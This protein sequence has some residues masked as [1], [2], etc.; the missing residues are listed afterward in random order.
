MSLIW[1]NRTLA[2]DFLKL[3]LPPGPGYYCSSQ[4]TN[5]I[6]T[7]TDAEGSSQQKEIVI[8]KDR[9]IT[10]LEGLAEVSLENSAEGF[11]T[12][13]A[14]SIFEQPSIILNGKPKFRAAVNA[15]RQ[16]SLWLDID[17]KGRPGEYNNV[18]DARDGLEEFIQTSGIPAPLIVCSGRGL[19]VYWPF[20]EPLSME[21]WKPL[22]LS[23]KSVCQ[24]LE[25]KVD[26][27][28]THDAASVL[29]IPG[30]KNYGNDGVVRD[31]AV[32]SWGTVT[33]PETLRNKFQTLLGGASAPIPVSSPARANPPQ[34]PTSNMDAL[35]NS[36]KT[37]EDPRAA[38]NGC[39]H[40]RQAG[41]AN[42]FNWYNALKVLTRC[43]KGREV[44]HLVSRE[45][46]Q[47][48]YDAAVVDEKFD[49]AEESVAGPPRCETFE[50]AEN[51]TDEG[52]C[53][54]CEYYKKYS[55]PLQCP[56]QRRTVEVKIE[57]PETEAGGDAAN[58]Y[59]KL[60]PFESDRFRVVK[61]TGIVWHKKSQEDGEWGSQD[62]LLAE[63]EL[64]LDHIN[65]E[66][67]EKGEP[68]RS[69]IFNC[70]HQ[71]LRQETI[72][73]ILSRDLRNFKEWLM[74]RHLS[75]P[76]NVP[77]K[78]ME[79]F[80]LAYINKMRHKVPDNLLYNSLGWRTV[81]DERTGKE[82][83]GFI[84]GEKRILPDR[85]DIIALSDICNKAVEKEFI[86]AGSLEE[87]KKV[88][89]MY[90][91]LNQKQGQ[92]FICAG[93]AAPFMSLH[94][95]ETNA[96]F[97][98]YEPYGG[99]GKSWVLKMVNSIWGHP[100]DMFGR[101]KDT[102]N[103]RYKKLAVRRHL[104]MCIDEVTT[105]KDEE[106]VDMLYTVSGGQEKDRLTGT[107]AGFVSGG[108]WDTITFFTANRSLYEKME[109]YSDQNTATKRRVIEFQCD[110]KDYTNTEHGPYID[111]MI[112]LV[113]N[114]YG[115]AGAYMIENYLRDA[116]A[117]RRIPAELE[118]MASEFSEAGSDS[119]WAAGMSAAIVAGRYAKSLGLI[120]YDMDD[121][122]DWAKTEMVGLR[123]EM[124]S[125]G[126]DAAAVLSSFLN[127]HYDSTLIVLSERRPP[128]MKDPGNLEALD[129][130]IVKKPMH[131]VLVRYARE[132]H[133]ARISYPA[134]KTWCMLRRLSAK[135]ILAEAWEQKLI[136]STEPVP[137]SLGNSVNAL[138]RTR[139]LAITLRA[140]QLD[141]DYEAA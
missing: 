30:T 124:T 86:S 88:V 75:P 127:E 68:H 63:R 111:R 134:F 41:H 114:N 38:V 116:E 82:Q 54:A 129:S 98:L 140:S 59:D 39:R 6:K 8:W 37:L 23:F 73:F 57:V 126:S 34:Q 100:S 81:L 96:M 113:G 135:T 16:K 18:E 67:D 7:I 123:K 58:E 106:L 31:V 56:P 80:M 51:G 40:L 87:W 112:A 27:H 128:D 117:Q 83:K 11:D 28:R 55:T 137:C 93:F 1:E 94:E 10:E 50:R 15:V 45:D 138:P 61:G 43:K 97:S 90:R 12:Y 121:L 33:Y 19:H 5:L 102:F 62:V 29:R 36:F 132:E 14:A 136:T 77:I 71:G 24:K 92:L 99:K 20:T 3:I 118:H 101:P 65:N 122:A 125:A 2:I 120:D 70:Y 46:V 139:V 95:K 133:M 104:P 103:A 35:V 84:L 47:G 26:H 17:A 119:F 21:Q 141:V 89:D 42:Y 69:F 76:D 48:R 13:Y 72:N 109:N 105:A 78:K 44:A 52:W 9:P 108:T 131:K 66:P 4:K 53:R 110:F 74:N 79:D 25:L 32:L 130:Y 91:V 22:A 49:Q 115:L 60:E 107:G 85:T 64:Y